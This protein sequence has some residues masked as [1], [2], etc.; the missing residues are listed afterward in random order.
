M[1]VILMYTYVLYACVGRLRNSGGKSNSPV[2]LTSAATELVMEISF[3]HFKCSKNKKNP[4]KK[5]RFYALV[6]V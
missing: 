1:F 2:G 5:L 4:P 6:S 3:A